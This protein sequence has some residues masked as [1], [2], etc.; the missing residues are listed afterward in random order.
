MKPIFLTLSLLILACLTGISQEFRKRNEPLMEIRVDFNSHDEAN[1][2]AGKFPLG[3]IYLN[4]GYAL[5]QVS[6]EELDYIESEGIHYLI[7]KKDVSTFA[8]SFWNS[9]DQYH[10]YDDIIAKINLLS[11]QYSAICKKVSYGYSVEGRELAAVKISDNVNEDE[12]EPEIMFDGGIHGDEVGGAENLIRFAEFLCESYGVDPEITDLVNDREI[13]LYIMVNPDGRVNMVRQNSN[14][15]DLNRDWGYMWGGDGSSPVY[16]SQVETKAIRNC[17]LDNQ[18]VIHTSYHSGTVFLAYTWSYRPDPTPDQA[19]IHQLA[20]IYAS[21]SGYDYLPYEQGYSG[22]YPINGSSKDAA[23]GTAGSIGWTME[24]SLDKQPAPSEI[25]YYYEINEPAMIA[26]IEHAG[27][28]LRGLVTDAVTG[29]AVAATIFVDDYFPCYTDPVNGDYYKYL[30]DGTY[31]VEARANGYQSMTQTAIIS[32]GNFTALNFALQPEYGHYAYRVIACH[33]PYD[34]FADEAHTPASLGAADGE[35]YSLGKWGW[36]VLDMQQVIMDG[37]GEEILV[38]EG[39]SDPEGYSCYASLSMD[40]PW[41]LLSNATGTSE[42]DFSTAGLNEAR[43]IRIVDDGEGPLTGNDAGFDLDA[44]EVPEKPQVIFLTLDALINDTQGN[45]NGRIDPGESFDMILT[46]RNLGSMALEN[47]Q[48]WLNI[49]Q[50]F[51]SLAD[52]YQSIEILAFGDSIQLIYSMGCSSFCPS[53]ELLMTVLNITSNNGEYQQSFPVN[54]SATPII[55]DWETANLLKFD[56]TTGGNKPWAIN[57]Q[58]P[59]QG[60]YTAKSGN[61]DDNQV[62]A[63]EVLMDVIGYDDISFYCKVSSEADGDFLRFY[64][65][66]NLK[67]QWSGEQTWEYNSYQVKPGIHTFKWS[68]E[69]DNAITHGNDGGWIDYIVFPSCNLGGELKVLANAIPHRICG[70]GESQLGAYLLGGSSGTVFEWSPSSTINNPALQFPVAMPESTTL[71]SVTVTQGETI[72][73]SGIEVSLHLVPEPPFIFQAGDSIVSS[74]GEGNQWYN[75]EGP[76]AGATGNVFYPE[77]EGDYFARSI[78]DE[79][80]SSD[81]SNIV[82]FIFTGI[83]ENDQPNFVSLYPNPLKDLLFIHFQEGP[84]TGFT[85]NLIDITGVTVYELQVFDPDFQEIITIPMKELRNGLFL[86]NITDQEGHILVSEK[87]MKL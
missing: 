50:Q 74:V 44:V 20:G 4:G 22:M 31:Q 14:G 55:E 33:A 80:C 58:D 86:L 72:I 79:G 35:R 87:L 34:N 12:T 7:L 46:I 61:I 77:T 54:Y 70:P 1:K 28:G 57:F 10:S 63:I 3:D 64:I 41:T 18:F 21:S 8:E 9:R 62:S 6:P 69:K 40:G 36:I 73:T 59:F 81:S 5:L 67:G 30:L 32:G 53:G 48:A 75:N 25:Q 56:W 66:N 78:S 47:G 13:W 23:Y 42:F 11:T 38:V 15:V 27:F 19:H 76:I 16:Y 45:S 39:D 52:P 71:Y 83:A 51:L 24:I 49:D 82:N 85:I 65:D 68:F 60:S 84:L 29:E 37:P 26:M 17:M 43:Y 2:I